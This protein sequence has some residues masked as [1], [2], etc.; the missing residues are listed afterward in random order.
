MFVHPTAVRQ[1]ALQLV[2]AGLNDCEVARRLGVP[3]RTVRD[4]RVPSYVPRERPRCL[5][6]WRPTSPFSFTPD[7]YAELLGLYLGDGHITRM[8]R[9]ERLRVMLDAKYAQIVADAADLL[10]RIA[11]FNKVG[12]QFPH[13][14]RMVTLHA[15]HAHWS[16][17]LPQHGPGKKHERPIVLR[18][19]AGGAGR[20]GAVGVPPRLHPLGRLR[21][22][23][24]DGALRLRVVRLL[25][26]VEGHPRSLR[27]GL[28]LRRRGLSRSRHSGAHQPASQRGV[29][30]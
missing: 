18:A 24:P 27:G 8:A 22:P 29:D 5:R 6:C 9:A 3:R 28:R 25:Q 23:E 7:D 15:Y 1:A 30:A 16:C 12:R 14:G 19:V 4:W 2:A 20:A 17:L 11:P 21:V 26:L 10:A 13:Q